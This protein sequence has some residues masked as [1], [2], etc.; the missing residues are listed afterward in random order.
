MTFWHS[1]VMEYEIRERTVSLA[2]SSK[3]L[4]GPQIVHRTKDI[5]DVGFRV[6]GKSCCSFG[7]EYMKITGRRRTR[8]S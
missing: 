1:H 6:T 4:E 7:N 8:A 5:F 3:Y 2:C